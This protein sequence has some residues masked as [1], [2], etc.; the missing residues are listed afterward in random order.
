M[1]I[2]KFIDQSP[3]NG[4][5][6]AQINAP[7]FFRIEDDDGLNLSTLKVLVENVAVI[8][9]GVFQPGYTGAI[10]N[11][12]PTPTAVSVVIV[13]NANWPYSTEI[14]VAAQIEDNTSISGI[15]TWSFLTIVDPDNTAPIVSATP[16]GNTFNQTISVTLAANELNTTI[17]YT[18]DGSDPTL[19]S[20]TYTS[21]IFISNE[22]ETV[23][24]FVGIDDSNN[25]DLTR[26]EIYNIDTVAPSTVAVPPGGQFFSSLEVNLKS[27]DP[28]AKIFYT[29]DN[30]LPTTSSDMFSTP[31]Q[32]PDNKITNL[33]FFGIDDAG[34][35]ESVKTETYNIFLAK[36][37]IIVKNVHVRHAYIR[38]ELEIVW[39]DMWPINTNVIG[40]NIYRSDEELGEYKKLNKDI[41]P[42]NQYIDKTLDV[43]IVEEDVSEQF[44]RTINISSEVNDDFSTSKIN[45]RKWTESDLAE[46]MFQFRGLIFK[47]SVG[48]TQTSKITSKFKLKGDFD[49]ETEFLLED[50]SEPGT[51][52][53]SSLLRVKRDDNNYIQI[54]RERSQTAN[55]YSSNKYTNGNPDL[56]IT[57]SS[58]DVEG[59]YR[60]VRNGNIIST[61][62]YDNSN[63]AF[64]LHHTFN[65]FSEDLYV[66]LVGV[67]ADKAMEIRWFNFILNSGTPVIIEPL[68]PL[69]EYVIGVS[70]TP[71][72]DST[73]TNTPTDDITEVEVFINGAKAVIKRVE[74]YEGCIYLETDKCWDEVA[75]QYYVPPVPDEHST[76][77]VNYKTPLHTT[78]IDLRKNHFY[79][80]TALT[81]CDETDLGVIQPSS[82]QSEQVDWIYAEAIR[83]NSWLREQAGERVL[84][85]IQKRAGS[86]CR[87]LGKAMLERTHRKANYDCPHC[88]GTG[89]EGGYFGP[90]NIIIGNL[91][92]E[93]RINQTERGLKLQNQ[94]ETW[95]GPYPILTQ[96][97]MILRRN[98]DRLAVG[99]ITK[100]EGPN[101]V[102]IQQ[103]FSVEVIDA[104]DIRYK[105]PI[106]PLPNQ[107]TPPSPIDKQGT[108]IPE[109][110]SPK[111][112]EELVTNF[113][114]PADDTEYEKQK[115]HDSNSAVDRI[116]R[117]RS[118]TFENHNY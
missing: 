2:P 45:P 44:R 95:T 61:Y 33:K 81:D 78:K 20:S 103:H 8:D 116:K 50:W 118:I 100:T 91:T 36:N 53:Q 108:T 82:L 49:I 94:V 29:V 11:E 96:R 62:F 102:L 106:Q 25:S 58:V 17:Y 107:Y 60:I 24:K 105:L 15:G 80:I 109:V 86:P 85:Y 71:I 7:I 113:D 21:P 13:P 48:L 56:P 26:T 51:K 5:I 14:N 43:E 63:D 38:N 12:N 99:P 90:I 73:N 35:Q 97:D 79:K 111:E 93:H 69:K 41:I 87:C 67:S 37:N 89:F 22:G 101:G 9:G 39:E 59:R 34:N 30:S 72:V 110:V 83:R 64:M 115:K 31:I 98:G 68:N 117:G 104:T 57:V 55:V 23:L 4:F 74:G 10:T 77:L 28:T 27:D 54:G 40:Y 112:R 3:Q 32:I 42:I 46:M 70:K 16:K 65:S 88:Y 18:L 6:G 52:I 114:T 66:E 47:D 75:K 84:L 1:P 19:A 76:I 92:S